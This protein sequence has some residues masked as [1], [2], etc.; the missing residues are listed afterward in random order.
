MPGDRRNIQTAVD[1]LLSSPVQE[2]DLTELA[3]ELLSAWGGP[4]QFARDVY[5]H[6]CDTQPGG[7][8][9]GQIIKT[10]LGVIEKHATLNKGDVRPEQRLDADELKETIGQLMA[11]MN[12]LGNEFTPPTATGPETSAHPPG[13]V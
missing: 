4:R 3:Q 9:K 10:V 11:D 13:S 2:V 5:Q 8:Q 6:Y 12:I 7:M 1:S